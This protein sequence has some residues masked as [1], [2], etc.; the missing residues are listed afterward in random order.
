LR[1]DRRQVELKL[2]AN[3][4]E[5]DSCIA[6]LMEKVM[7]DKVDVAIGFISLQYVRAMFLSETRPFAYAALGIVSELVSSL[8]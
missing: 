3:E 4:D 7:Q 2:Y 5:I 1:T 6:G 8:D